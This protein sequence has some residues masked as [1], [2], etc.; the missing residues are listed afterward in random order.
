MHRFCNHFCFGFRFVTGYPDGLFGG[1][2]VSGIVGDL[3]GTGNCIGA[4]RAIL[5]L[6]QKLKA[7]GCEGAVVAGS[8]A[9]IQPILQGGTNGRKFF[10]T[11]N[12]YIPGRCQF[13]FYKVGYGYGKRVTIE[14]VSHPIVEGVGNTR[15]PDGEERTR[16]VGGIFYNLE[17]RGAV[18]FKCGFVPGYVGT[19]FVIFGIHGH[20]FG[21]RGKLGHLVVAHNYRKGA[22]LHITAFIASGVGNQGGSLVKNVIVELVNAIAG[23]SVFGGATHHPR[24]RGECAGQ[25][26]E[27][28]S[29]TDV[30]GTFVDIGIG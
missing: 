11:V 5:A 14:V 10:A 25:H 24:K 2:N 20:I 13:G 16:L 29:V 17:K 1:G 30:G 12:G 4:N 19:T 3:V 9:G 21:H 15:G 6:S 7:G 8:A 27:L 23:R 26:F 28:Q 18:V 22:R